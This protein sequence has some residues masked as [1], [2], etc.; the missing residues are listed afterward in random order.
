MLKTQ[1]TGAKYLSP[2]TNQ[3][4]N[5]NIAVPADSKDTEF[6]TSDILLAKDVVA[7]LNTLDSDIS[8]ELA[9]QTDKITKIN[10]AIKQLV[11]HNLIKVVTELPTI[12]IDKNC[13]YLV[14]NNDGEGD[15]VFIE[16]IFVEERGSFEE[17]GRIQA[18]IN[19]SDYYTKKEID[20]KQ[21]I[22]MSNGIDKQVHLDATI[23]FVN[24]SGQI[25]TNTLN[26]DSINLVDEDANKKISLN[27]DKNVSYKDANDPIRIQLTSDDA[28]ANVI[29]Y[30]GFTHKTDDKFE[31]RACGYGVY[32]Q[33]D[34][35]GYIRMSSLS[36]D[37]LEFRTTDDQILQMNLGLDSDGESYCMTIGSDE[38]FKISCSTD[39]TEGATITG[40][41]SITAFANPSSTEVWSTDGSTVNLITYTKAMANLTAR[42]EQL[43]TKVKALEDANTPA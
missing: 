5:L 10:E 24:I 19:L 1:I 31:L 37:N 15:N 30:D 25:C 33:H 4:T 27:V 17:V 41:K 38:K 2:Q 3:M 39:N 13:I 14:A 43:E 26:S 9:T 28:E 12:N 16:Y 40:V 42:I 6:G 20:S 18:K 21:T 8:K 23:P 32:L 11:N 7:Y 36:K 22:Y 35:D 29:A 34:D